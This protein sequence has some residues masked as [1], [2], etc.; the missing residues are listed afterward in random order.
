[1][2]PSGGRGMSAIPPPS[3]DKQTPSERAAIAAFDPE[4]TATNRV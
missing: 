2:A 3:G 1:M 4:Q